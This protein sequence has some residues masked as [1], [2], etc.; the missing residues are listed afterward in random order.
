MVDPAPNVIDKALEMEPQL[1]AVMQD[2]KKES[3][4]DTSPE[5]VRYPFNPSQ[6]YYSY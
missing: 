5:Q 1:R 2:I 4:S 6:F 3:I